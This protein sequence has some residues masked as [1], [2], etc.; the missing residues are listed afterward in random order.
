MPIVFGDSSGLAQGITQAGG[1]L[2][3][4]L[5]QRAQNRLLGQQKEQQGQQFGTL[6]DSLIGQGGDLGSLA[7][8]L[9]DSGVGP[10]MG[11]P[12]V[13]EAFK[14]SV[15]PK[16]GT[17]DPFDGQSEEELT[18]T[19]VGIGIPEDKAPAFAKMYMSSSTGGKT[20]FAKYMFDQLQ[21]GAF[22]SPAQD[23]NARL[24]KQGPVFGEPVEEL[25]QEGEDQLS[26]QAQPEQGQA[27]Y[28]LPE[29]TPYE[30]MTPTEAV[31]HK[32]FLMKE[33]NPLIQENNKKVKSLK[34]EDRMIKQMMRLDATD[35]LPS[36]AGRLNVSVKDGKLNLPAGANAETQTYVKMINDWTTKAKESYGARVTNFDLEQFM[37]RLPTLA[38]S[39]EGRRLIQAQMLAVNDLNRL[40]YGSIQ[41]VYDQYGA[42]GI[43]PAQ[44]DMFARQLSGTK[45]GELE[46]AYIDSMEAQTVYDMNQ[47]L[48]PGRLLV[49]KDGLFKQIRADQQEVATSKGWRVR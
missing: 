7:Q 18:S 31:K 47:R 6:L 43:D 38:N 17:P 36:G 27:D 9:K 10:E 13:Q 1:A 49:S 24:Q 39:Q 29:L 41:Q 8:S 16:L 33:N 46:Q 48:E 42:S 26:P 35:K 28:Q 22:K 37:A 14:Q 3:G 20:Q 32:Q 45:E 5:Q 4:A 12:L 30:G 25:F 40:H 34:D 23:L 11:G 19:L 44:A 15:R 2:A 21:R